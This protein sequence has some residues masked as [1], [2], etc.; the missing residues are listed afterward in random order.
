MSKKFNT[1][2]RKK[3][4]EAR[5]SGLSNTELKRGFGIKDNRTLERH[6]KLAEQ[7]ERSLLVDLEILKDAKANHLSEIRT[8]IEQWQVALATP[9]IHAV[10]PGTSSPIHDVEAHPLYGSLREHLPFPTLW[11]DHALFITKMSKYLETCK[12]LR[13][14]IRERWKIQDTELAR[15]F[16]D[17]ILRLVDGTDEKLRYKLNIGVGHELK[18]F[19]YQVVVVNDTE[20]VRGR[21]TAGQ[22]FRMLNHEQCSKEALPD[23]YQKVADS[24]YETGASQAKGLFQALSELEAKL[25]KSLQEI[26]LRRDYIM[27]TCKLCPGQPRLSR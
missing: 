6:L 21:E 14:R 24:I 15:S 25:H 10:Y 4:F 23:E 1:Y 2:E 16:E 8:L 13:E 19:K 18:E 7:E 22:Q 3:L 27:Y 9:Q 5:E 26:Q 11:R 17:P 12:E 20:V